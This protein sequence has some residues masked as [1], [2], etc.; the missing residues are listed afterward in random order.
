[1][2]GTIEERRPQL[3]LRD[4]LRLMRPA[5]AL[6]GE[7][8]VEHGQI[9]GAQLEAALRLQREWRSHLGYV[10]IAKGWVRPQDWYRAVA[11]PS[12]CPSSI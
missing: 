12:P 9:T 11:A 7:C 2:D 1:M 6:V 5:D 4:R 3:L 8:L 10:L